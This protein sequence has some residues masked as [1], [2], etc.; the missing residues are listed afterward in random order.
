M[1]CAYGLCVRLGKLYLKSQIHGR[2][3]K[4][5]RKGHSSGREQCQV[6]LF[7]IFRAL[8]LNNCKLFCSESSLCFS[9]QRAALKREEFV[10]SVPSTPPKKWPR[11]R[12]P[13]RFLPGFS[14][15]WLFVPQQPDLTMISALNLSVGT[16]LQ[17]KPND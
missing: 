14:H 17:I 13:S 6:K 8:P 1:I 3:G 7:C 2:H 10:V 12:N 16:E 4:P 9:S 15:F 11:D 5:E